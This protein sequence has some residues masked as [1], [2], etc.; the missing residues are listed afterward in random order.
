MEEGSKRQTVPKFCATR[1]SAKVTNLCA[2][3]AKYGSILLPPKEISSS[4]SGDVKRDASAYSRL[5]QDSEFIVALTVSQFVLSFL[6]QVTKSLQAKS[7]NL[8]DAYQKATLAKECIKSARGDES[9]QKVW[10]RI[11]QVADSINVTLIK[12]RT[13]T[14]QG[15]RANAAHNDQPSDYYRINGFYLFI[16]HVVGEL[17]TRF[18]IQHEGLKTAQNPFPLYLPKLTDRNIEKIKNYFSKH[19]DFSEKS[20]FDAELARWRMKHPMEPRSEQE[21]TM[22]N[23]SQQEFSARCCRF[24]K[25]RLSEASV[26]NALSQPYTV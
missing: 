3:L 14:V 22:P 17:E 13:T 8:G 6:A 9:G 25:P 5:L 24:F 23:C 11:S 16:D 20:Y 4:S 19:L 21:G 2:L 26:A 12:P 1:W 15:H 7:C 10:S 18:S